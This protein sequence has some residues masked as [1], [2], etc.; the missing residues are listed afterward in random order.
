MRTRIGSILFPIP[1]VK[2]LDRQTA[3]TEVAATQLDRR[4]RRLNGTVRRRPIRTVAGHL[5]RGFEKLGGIPAA[6]ALVWDTRFDLEAAGSNGFPAIAFLC[7][8]PAEAMLRRSGA[9]AVSRD[10]AN[11]LSSYEEKEQIAVTKNR[12]TLPAAIPYLR[13]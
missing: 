12:S 6:T 3:R 1:E 5:C 8:G 10:P 13:T 11:L 2:P 9:R 7:G 4:F